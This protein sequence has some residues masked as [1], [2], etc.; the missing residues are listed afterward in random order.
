MDWLAHDR[1]GF[2]YRLSDV[3]AAIGV[4]QLERLDEL[5]AERDRVAA[6]TASA[7]RDRGARPALPRRGAERRSWFVYVVQ[8]PEEVDRD[9]VIAALAERG[10]A[11]KAYLPCIHLQP[12][13][14]ERFGF[15][16]G[17]FPVAE[18]VAARSLALPF[19]TR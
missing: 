2:N 5:L 7:S 3:A 11:S 1:L 8:V 9:G 16:G 12:F 10:I 18:R 15:R 6:C 17:E 4:A 14:R 19:F 13:Y